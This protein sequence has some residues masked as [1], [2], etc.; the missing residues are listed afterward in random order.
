MECPACGHREMV[1]KILDETLSYGSQSLTLHT[2]HG[3]FCPACGEGVWDA[4]S[5]RRYSEVQ[6]ALLRAVK[7]DISH[8]PGLRYDERGKSNV[9][10]MTNKTG[11]GR[12]GTEV[13]NH[14]KGGRIGK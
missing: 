3:E 7:G 4:E 1:A 8:D 12:I 9:S 10:S 5:Y 11:N 13:T 2:M 6:A 14:D